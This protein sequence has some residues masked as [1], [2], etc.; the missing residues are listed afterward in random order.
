MTILNTKVTILLNNTYKKILYSAQFQSS[1]YFARGTVALC[2]IF[3]IVNVQLQKLRVVQTGM[4][5]K[6]LVHLTLHDLVVISVK[7]HEGVGLTVS[8]EISS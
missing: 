8:Y 3:Y 2:T 1:L 5:F 4:N 7:D 6:S